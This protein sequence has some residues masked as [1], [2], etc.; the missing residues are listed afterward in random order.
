MSR[1]ERPTHRLYMTFMLS[2]GSWSCQFLEADAKTPLPRTLSFADA[3]KIR[4][5]ARRGEE[6][7]NLENKRALEHALETGERYICGR[8]PSNA[9]VSVR[10]LA[11]PS[12]LDMS[13]F[14]DGAE[15]QR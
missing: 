1:Y 13:R 8:H 4:E 9:S 3:E 6:W 14:Y 12:R 2:H 7:G 10:P 15:V 5:L 11:Q